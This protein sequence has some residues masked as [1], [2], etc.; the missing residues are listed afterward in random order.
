MFRT[1]YTAKKKIQQNPIHID[2][3]WFK[4][5]VTI[6]G[7]VEASLILS[8]CII[9]HQNKYRSFYVDNQKQYGLLTSISQIQRN[10]NISYKRAKQVLKDLLDQELIKVHNQGFVYNQKFY[11]PTNKALDAVYK[12]QFKRKNDL[13][14]YKTRVEPLLS[15]DQSTFSDRQKTF[16]DK[17][18][19]KKNNNHNTKQEAN[20]S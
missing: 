1:S 19:D 20:H 10:Y 8:D 5:V 7:S 12:L 4:E 6:T 3:K 16:K 11:T 9:Y 18:E 13:N 17:N 15:I 2:S 14:Q